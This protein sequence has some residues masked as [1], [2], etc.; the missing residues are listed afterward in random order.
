MPLGSQSLFSNVKFEAM[1]FFK[2]RKQALILQ[3]LDR[4]ICTFLSCYVEALEDRSTC[5]RQLISCSIHENENNIEVP[6]Q[7]LLYQQRE[8]RQK[9]ISDSSTNPTCTDDII[10]HLTL[11]D[12]AYFM[13]TF[14]DIRRPKGNSHRILLQCQSMV[15]SHWTQMACLAC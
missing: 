10:Q 9:A 4:Y 13:H 8:R 7:T 3:C 15:Q 5:A 14:T 1:N 6:S 2:T 11:S 12:S